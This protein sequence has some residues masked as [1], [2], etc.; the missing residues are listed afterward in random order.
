MS[1]LGLA[2]DY[3]A[4]Q[5][6]AALVQL[7]WFTLSLEMPRYVLGF[8]TLGLA[9]ALRDRRRAAALV[10]A[11]PRPPDPVRPRVSVI[12]V[13]HNEA[14][15][16][17]RCLLSL[18]EQTL[19]PLEVVVV[20]DGSADGMERVAA[21]L[22]RQGLASHALATDLR[23]GK[24]AG[25]NLA[26]RT[27]RGEIIVN[28]DCDCS[29]DR[30][31]LENIVA[32]FADPSVAA[33]SGDIAPRNG[34]RSL[35]ARLQQIEYMI[36]IS[37]GRRVAD[38]LNQVA[39][40][41]GAFG[42][43]RREALL[44]VGGCDVGGGEDLDLTLRLR[45]AG[46]RTAFA[47]D[48]ICYTDVPERLW[49][50]VRQRLRWDRDAIRLR[51]RK[52]R[53]TLLGRDRGAS[54]A[55]TVHQLDFLVFDFG[56]TVIFPVYLAWLFA[57]YGGMALS[58]LLAM[59][60]GLLLLD[61]SMLALAAVIVPRPVPAATLLYLPG[62]SI[63]SGWVMRPVRLLAYVQEWFLFGSRQDNYVPA[64]VRHIRKW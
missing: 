24:S 6:T 29:Y 1:D 23:G 35:T 19:K 60:A 11:A 61:A 52:H 31:A 28:V 18:R 49:A 34:D 59:Q 39:C 8:L 30:F 27:C 33:V 48:A 21:R 37:V 16:L 42:A 22:M 44:E 2:L 47:P 25:F 57:L 40:V 62:Y 64:A 50:L 7:F 15:A 41:S 5:S 36:S 17:E 55:E 43:F 56:V 26:A 3:L 54:L 20:S 9:T 63:Y 13:G 46:W 32:P 51:F 45:A 58:I 12:V 10:A 53:R 14:E 38:S 4:S